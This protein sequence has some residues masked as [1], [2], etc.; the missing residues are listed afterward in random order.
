M[1]DDFHPDPDAAYARGRLLQTQHRIQDAIACYKQALALDAQHTPS[2]LM[3]ALC[4]MNEA[5]TAAQ[6]VDAARRAVALEPENAFA[7][8][9]LALTLDANAKDG[10]T[11][12]IKAALQEAEA[13][14]SLDPDSDFSHAVLARLHLRLRDFPQAEAAARAALAL[15]TENTMA[16]EVL[17]AALLLQKKDADNEDLIRYQL[18]RNAE[19]DSA[20][21]SAGWMAIMRGDHKQANQH[22][23]EALRINPMSENARMGLIESFRARSWPYRM[24]LKFAHFMN[25]FTEGRQTAI[26]LGGFFAYKLLSSYLKTVSPFLAAVVVGAW[27]LLVLWAHLARG[28]GS[29][30]M[31]MDRFARQALRPREYW[32]GVVVGGLIFA[33]IASLVLGYAWDLS[34]GRFAALACIFAAVVNAAAFT[35]DHWVGRYVYGVAAALSGAGALWIMVDVFSGITLPFA[36]PIGALAILLGVATTWMRGFGV[37]Y[38]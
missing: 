14:V 16:A 24:Q 34:E 37:L 21:T 2:Y 11:S 29:A 8:S 27:L 19:D 20:H 38:R 33:A 3:L 35:N 15:D 32:E 9:V 6:S 30:F 26:M 23:L 31:V 10:Q 4:W 25:Q 12:A 5:D 13:A 18:Q 22:F 7:R 17:S 36:G 28:F 1:S